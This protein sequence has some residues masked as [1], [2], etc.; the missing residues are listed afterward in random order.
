MDTNQTIYTSHLVYK[1]NDNWFRLTPE[2]RKE[3]LPQLM[4]VLE[5]YR[6][7]ITL[8]GIYSSVGFRN[9]AD[10][11]FW[12]LS[13]DVDLLQEF[14]V[15]IRRTTFGQATDTPWV[16]PGLTRKPEFVGDH[17]TAFQLGWDPQKYI[18]LYPFVR[19]PE[20]YLMP[21]EERGKMLKEHGM[22]GREFPM[23]Q[24]N[25]VQAF[26]ISDYEWILC[27]ECAEYEKFVDLV[28][29]LRE[30]EARRYTKLDTPFIIGVRKSLEEVLKDFA[31]ETFA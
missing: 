28:R 2:Q 25:N 19:T 1:R 31:P 4:E 29:H 3:A 17:L 5:K 24:T 14:A 23:V 7:R 10:V 22:M 13:N 27:F 8:R 26:G 11:V 9:D 6:E 20:W 30:A 18:C 21:R 16:F 12:A 15:D